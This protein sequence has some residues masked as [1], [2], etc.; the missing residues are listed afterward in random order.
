MPQPYGLKRLDTIQVDK[1]VTD[2]MLYKEYGRQRDVQSL[3]IMT[4]QLVLAGREF[5]GGLQVREREGNQLIKRTLY[6]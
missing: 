1:R 5:T 2:N 6:I 3:A 4:K